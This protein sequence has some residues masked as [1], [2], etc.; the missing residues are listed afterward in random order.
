M[1]RKKS[2]FTF[3]TVLLIVGFSFAATAADYPTK[4]VQLLIPFG[5][6]GAADTIGRMLSKAVEGALGQPL[7]AVN[8]PGAGGGIMYTALKNSKPDGYTLGFNSAGLLTV[9]NIGNVPFKY[10][11]FE[12][13]C[14]IGYEGV[15]ISVRSDAP[16]K[17][18]QE[19]VDYAKKN[20]NKIKIG[21]AGTG[22]A[23]HM[24]PIAMEKQ[25][26][27][28]FVHVPLGVK[29]RVPSLLGGEVDAICVPTPEIAPQVRAG[30]A[31]VLVIPSAKRDPAYPDVPTLNE[32]GGD[33][34]MELFRG[35]SVPKGTPAAIVKKLESAF[36]VAIE[37]KDFLAFCQKNNFTVSFMGQEEFGKYM[38]NMD[39]M[40]AKIMTEAGL[41]KK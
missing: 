23:T 34:E 39:K 16:W 29:R 24:T 40:V 12:N 20:P 22:S 26:G 28:K 30:K 15:P 31:R 6:G 27:L 9:T 3:F 19:F 32:M 21:N 7:V 5:A 25:M 8:K 13:V 35:I 36:K 18:F 11:A 10:D 37:D 41:K 38:A 1:I 33:M 14:R 17:T 2:L 4:P